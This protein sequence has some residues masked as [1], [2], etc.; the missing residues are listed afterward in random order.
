MFWTMTV[1]DLYGVI[2]GLSI[3]Q[4]SSSI[5]GDPDLVV[6]LTM[7]THDWVNLVGEWDFM[8]IQQNTL[9]NIATRGGHDHL[10][11]TGTEKPERKSKHT[12]G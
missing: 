10:T 3:I 12:G 11:R 2:S 6:D 4:I 8:T 1:I 5:S 9:D 7:T